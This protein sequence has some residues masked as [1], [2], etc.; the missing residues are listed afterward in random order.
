M[1]TKFLLLF[2]LMLLAGSVSAQD[3]QDETYTVYVNTKA[4]GVHKEYDHQRG[5]YVWRNS[6]GGFICRDVNMKPISEMDKYVYFTGVNNDPDNPQPSDPTIRKEWDSERGCYVWRTIHG[7]FLGRDKPSADKQMEWLNKQNSNWL[8]KGSVPKKK[9]SP[10]D[11]KAQKEIAKFVREMENE[12]VKAIQESR[13]A[14]SDADDEAYRNKHAGGSKRQ[15]VAIQQLLEN[16]D[17]QVANMSAQLNYAWEQVAKYHKQDTY[18]AIVENARNSIYHY[19]QR[20]QA[21]RDDVQMLEI[22]DAWVNEMQ[23]HVNIARRVLQKD[24]EL[25]SYGSILTSIEQGLNQYKRERANI[26]Y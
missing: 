4:P 21:Y 7:D 13:Q 15:S 5:E 18:G 6:M 2:A 22:A 9:L 16:F 26:S 1:K 23:Q 11:E 3:T 24:D 8:K 25:E 20:R 10:E 14:E 12:Q 19:Q 17:H